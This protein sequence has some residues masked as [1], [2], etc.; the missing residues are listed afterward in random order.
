MGSLNASSNQ[1]GP[2]KTDQPDFTSPVYWLAHPVHHPSRVKEALPAASL[3][4]EAGKTLRDAVKMPE[5]FSDCQQTAP[6]DVFY[7]HGTMEGWG[8][9]ASINRYEQEEWEGFN[10]HHQMKCVTAFTNVC[11]AFAPLYRQSAGG[12][13]FELAYQDVLAAF[14]QYLIETPEP[15]PLILA[16]HSQGSMHL[17]R[18]VQ[19]RVVT[20]AAVM[21]RVAGVFAP[22]CSLNAHS[23]APLVLEN[24]SA[25]SSEGGDEA[26]PPTAFMWAVVA[27]EVDWRKTLV[28]FMARGKALGPCADP[29]TW[30]S[31][32]HLG[33]LLQ[34][35]NSREPILYRGVISKTQVVDGLVRIHPAPGAEAFLT[36]MSNHD[37]HA[38]DITLFWGNIRERTRQQ[39]EAFLSP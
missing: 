22:G 29:G 20:D 18:L 26:V 13:S 32:G 5:Y 25:S 36:R 24:A 6:A 31:A 7:L 21:A 27:P 9:R 33:V 14:E 28:G 23:L 15:R 35:E 4:L 30:A 10:T 17:L 11:R 38:Y 8:N 16:G 37:Y 19:D 34:D 3:T 39:V 1:E 2:S 12:G